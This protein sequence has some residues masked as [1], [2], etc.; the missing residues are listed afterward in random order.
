MRCAAAARSPLAHRVGGAPID[1]AGAGD[2]RGGG[3]RH[4]VNG[5]EHAARHRSYALRQAGAEVARAAERAARQPRGL[6]ST[7]RLRL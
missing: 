3:A 1:A 2:E 7:P 4:I 6:P 5:L